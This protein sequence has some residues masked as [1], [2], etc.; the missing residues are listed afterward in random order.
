M[1]KQPGSEPFKSVSAAV[2]AVVFSPFKRGDAG[3]YF[4]CERRSKRLYYFRVKIE[5][6]SSCANCFQWEG[7]DR[8]WGKAGAE[9][10]MMPSLQ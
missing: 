4:V 10:E 1:A 5:R 2:I 8:R 3:E 9:S 6:V 7:V